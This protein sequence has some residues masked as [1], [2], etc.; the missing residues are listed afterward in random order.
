MMFIIKVYYYNR[1]C[2]THTKNLG[3]YLT[4]L[5]R[6]ALLD[7]KTRW[8]PPLPPWKEHLSKVQPHSSKYAKQTNSI[9]NVAVNY[10]NRQVMTKEWKYDSN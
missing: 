7:Y 3:N 2:K 4:S 9:F 10:M 5:P 1:Y 8:V 6:P